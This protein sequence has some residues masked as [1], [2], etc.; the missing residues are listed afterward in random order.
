MAFLCHCSRE[1][2]QESTDGHETFLCRLVA[3]LCGPENFP[4]CGPGTPGKPL[5]EGNLTQDGIAQDSPL[6]MAG[7][8]QM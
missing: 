8:Q 7:L 4:R 5:I 2:S 1:H 6:D 3:V